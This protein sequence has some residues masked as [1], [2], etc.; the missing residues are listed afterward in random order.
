MSRLTT[1]LAKCFSG[2]VH[3]SWTVKRSFSLCWWSVRLAA[4]KENSHEVLGEYSQRMF[5]YN[6]IP[7]MFLASPSVNVI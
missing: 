1:D 7:C 6:I 5:Q 4:G 3:D 2:T